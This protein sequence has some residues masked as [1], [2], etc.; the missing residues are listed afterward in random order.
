MENWMNKNI[1]KIIAI[2]LLLQPI[3]DLLTGVCIN[4]LHW[5]ITIGIIVRVIFLLWIC[6]IVLFVFKKKKVLIPYLIIGL[7]FVFYTIGMILY[8]DSSIVTELQN[9]VR[10]FYFPILLVSFY[11]IRDKIRISNM[12]FLT[13]ILLYILFIFVPT[14]IGVGYK[15]YQITKVGTLGFFN[16]ANEISGIISILTPLLFVVF[17]KSKKI[18]PILLFTIMYLIVIL[19]V[20]TKTP[21]LTLIITT[22]ISML[23]LWVYFYKEKKYKQIAISIGCIL[24]LCLGMVLI[25]P[26]TNFYKN[27]KTHLNYLGLEHVTEVFKDKELVDHFIFSSRL[28]FMHNKAYIYKTS[29]TYEKIFGIGYINFD[30]ETKQIEMDYFD[31]Y[32]SHGLVGFLIYFMIVL[33][34]L[35]S[36]LEKRK[37]NNYEE[38]MR[39]LSLFLIC[40]LAFFTG[41]ILTAPSVSIIA[42]LLFLSIERRKKKDLLFADYNLGIGGIEKA[43]I[44]LLE[45]IDYEKYNVVLVLERKEGELLDRVPKEVNIKELKVSENKDVIIRKTINFLRK[46]LFKIFEYDNY[47]FSCCYTTYSYSSNKI[48][49]IASVNSALYIH[50]DY[51]HVFETEE[52]F[53]EFFDTRNIYEFKKLVF[54]SKESQKSFLET[55]KDVKEKTLV[56][57]N[58]ID[59]KE[60]QKKSKEEIELKK[61]KNKKLLVFVGRLDDASKKVSRAIHLVKEIK[62]IELW[63]IG[64]GPDRNRYEQEVKDLKLQKEI[65]F[66]GSKIN[67]YPYMKEADY[68]I[69]TS[70]YEG[71]PVTYLEA[72]ALKKNIITTIP[73]SD[74]Y[75]DMKE[76]AYI[77]SKEEK[78]M[79]KE[80][81]NILKEKS[82][83]KQID[84]EKIQA[85]R[86]EK[87]SILFQ[88]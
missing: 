25:I 14:I 15:T 18:V 67:P 12:T 45:N 80:V 24:V 77:I 48:A 71:F 61:Q 43:Q 52:E 23:Y 1:N 51:K 16:S 79:V 27:I 58:F 35:Y 47:D 69:L 85:Y 3:L 26:K 53:R 41:H 56:M 21:L 6:L 37:E 73:T 29:S 68:I 65:T 42:I 44:N 81:K 39:L 31:I 82:T 8:K 55:Y 9:L 87:L 50:S 20:G 57:N 13:M 36:L 59:I 34:I 40:F 10:A 38:G 83:K 88:D 60:I 33:Y 5:S 74:D 63:I 19:M 86:K 84:L 54:V 2:F 28:K 11:A 30:K 49:R 32:Y 66:A 75:I 76:Y 70:D 7:Y 72:M 62:E 46:L 17:Y 64:D 78:E 22:G 4:T